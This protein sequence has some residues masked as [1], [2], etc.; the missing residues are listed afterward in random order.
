[1]AIAKCAVFSVKTDREIGTGQKHPCISFPDKVL[2]GPTRPRGIPL[3]VRLA[4]HPFDKIKRSAYFL[5]FFPISAQQPF[6][7]R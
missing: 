5:I 7:T 1:M 6:L 3:W 2:T 4:F